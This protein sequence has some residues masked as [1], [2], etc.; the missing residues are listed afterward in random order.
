MIENSQRPVDEFANR[1]IHMDA[2]EL[3]A[4][5]PA[6][7]VNLFVT[8]PPYADQRAHTYGGVAP[9]EYVQ[10]FLPIADEIQRVLT[11]DGPFILSCSG[12]PFAPVHRGRISLHRNKRIP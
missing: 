4:R 5:L 7:A 10:W 8:S 9:G 6:R 2:L 11:E 1:I 12:A 3:C